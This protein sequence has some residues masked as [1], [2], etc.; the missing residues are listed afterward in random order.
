M[1]MMSDNRAISGTACDTPTN[2]MPTMGML[3]HKTIDMQT[4]TMAMICHIINTMW[5][6]DS[7]APDFTP[8]GNIMAGLAAINENQRAIMTAVKAIVDKL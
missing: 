2:E 4:E 5:G 8:K 1:N 7:A 6:D 3:I